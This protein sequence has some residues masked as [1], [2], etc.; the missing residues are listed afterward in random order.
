MAEMLLTR[1]IQVTFLVREESFWNNVLPIEESAIVN[2]IIRKHDIDLQ[3]NTEL[4]EI[5]PDESGRAK[6][7]MTSTDE[8]IDC[9]FVGLTAGVQPNIDFLKK[10]TNRY[11]SG[12]FGQ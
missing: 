3:L 5:I 4:K 12:N 9:S 8:R 10:S 1:N 7:V 6:A 11:R 2:R